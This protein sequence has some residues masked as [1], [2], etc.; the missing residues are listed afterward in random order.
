MLCTHALFH[1]RTCYKM[2]LLRSMQMAYVHNA[3]IV[4]V[5]RLI[6]GD[7]WHSHTAM[8]RYLKSITYVGLSW[9]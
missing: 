4:Y 2:L 9:R 6:P 8:Q 7:S 3:C 1:M 5:L